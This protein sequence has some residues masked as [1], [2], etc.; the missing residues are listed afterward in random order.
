MAFKLI[1][2]PTAKFDLKDIAAFIAEDSASA[3]GRFV[4]SLFQ[5]VERLDDFPES[6]R[7][8]PEFGDP[9]I[10]EV[11]RKPCRIV[12]RVDS[13]KRIIEIARVWH[14]AGGTPTIE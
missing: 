11:I 12:Y 5:A 4:R 10:R 8:V 2:S 7:I 9:A 14:A 13:R 6:G 1:W 3:A